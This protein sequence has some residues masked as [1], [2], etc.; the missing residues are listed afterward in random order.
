MF[1]TKPF[2]A[3]RVA[4]WG[5]VRSDLDGYGDADERGSPLVGDCISDGRVDGRLNGRED[6]LQRLFGTGTSQD[7]A[8]LSNIARDQQAD[9]AFLENVGQLIEHLHCGDI[10]ERN[11]AGVKHDSVHA[12]GGGRRLDA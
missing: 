2:G 5:L 10:D 11:A 1:D 4:P 9:V 3:A 6:A 12:V 7:V 8:D